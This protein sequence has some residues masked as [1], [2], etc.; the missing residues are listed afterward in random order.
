M[1]RLF[2]IILPL[3]GKRGIAKYAALGLLS[4][5]SSF[6]FITCVNKVIAFLIK[7]EYTAVRKEY[8]IGFSLIILVFI[9]GRRALA[10]HIMNLSQRITWDLRKQIISSILRADYEELAARK[11][12]IQT[13]ILNDVGSLTNASIVSID[14]FIHVFMAVSCLVYM[15]TI[16]LVLFFITFFIAILG[17]TIH[18]LSTKRNMHALGAGRYLENR[19]QQNITAILNGFKEI[20]MEPKKGKHINEK[21]ISVIAKDSIKNNIYALTGMINN[22][23]IGQILFYILVSS[24]LLI[25]SITLHMEAPK[26]VSFVFA[27]MYLLGA[28]DATVSLLPMLM[29]AS[30][31]SKHLMDLKEELES[32][33]LSKPFL[34]TSALYRDLTLIRVKDLEYT[35]SGMDSSFSIGPINM[36]I[37]KGEVIFIYGGNGS[38]KTT[39]VYSLLGLRTLSAGQILVNDSPVDDANY[40]DYRGMFAVVFSDFYLF[41]EVLGVDDI[42][43]EKWEFLLDLFE[44]RG[45]VTLEGGVLSTTDLSTGQRKRLA[46]IV[47]L[48]EKKPILVMDEWAADQDPIFRRKFY[49]EIIPFL[50][51]E[52]LSIIA[53]THDDKYYHCADKV[54][55]M[56]EGKLTHDQSATVAAAAAFA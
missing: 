44:I 29:G 24:I 52:G 7:E 3:V 4:G 8:I 47:T 15:A 14:F 33:K 17:L 5:L 41:D 13:T 1:K 42:D 36:N 12:K 9:W 2:K 56:E 18:T 49:T 25:F 38:G 46:L 22:T 54:Y 19:F 27:L 26:V 55:K 34:E 31:A 28:L 51:S 10:M 32:S 40:A 48:L 6:L 30:V 39:F 11:D 50:K 21:R 20:Y 37:R 16:S 45:K 23:V 35:Y 43:V 53:V